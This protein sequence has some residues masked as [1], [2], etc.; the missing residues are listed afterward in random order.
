MQ[1][2]LN[3]CVLLQ[4]FSPPCRSGC[5]SGMQIR[6]DVLRGEL[7]KCAGSPEVFLASRARFTK[8][9][10]CSTGVL[11]WGLGLWIWGGP[12]CRSQEAFLA[13]PE[14]RKFHHM[15]VGARGL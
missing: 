6:W 10:T 9:V 13:S 3:N 7:L 8:W 14:W 5:I 4:R 2:M 12:G 11:A 15:G 1:G